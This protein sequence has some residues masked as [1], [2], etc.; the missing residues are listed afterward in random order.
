MSDINGLKENDQE[1]LKFDSVFD[2]LEF[3]KKKCEAFEKDQFK[4]QT[5]LKKNEQIIKKLQDMVSVF[6]KVFLIIN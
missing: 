5:N 3:F 1:K 6:G 2:E 4:M